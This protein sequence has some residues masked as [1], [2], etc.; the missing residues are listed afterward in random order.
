METNDRELLALFDTAPLTPR[1]WATVVLVYAQ[2]AFEFF[3]YFLVGYL[4]AVLAQPW[5]LTYGQS[6]IMLLSAGV[7]AIV[8]STVLGSLADLFGCRRLLLAGA[9]FY[10]LAAGLIAVVPDGAWII[11]SI[12]RFVVGVGMAGAITAQI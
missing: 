9:F 6:A 4:V 3:D 1:F 11:F 10:P 12:L 2:A 7:G 5:H 8:G